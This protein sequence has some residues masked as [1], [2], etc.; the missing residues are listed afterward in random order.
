MYWDRWSTPCPGR[1]TP[2]EDTR[3]PLYRRLGGSI[4][5]RK[6]SSQPRVDRR[7]VH[8]VEIRSFV[9]FVQWLVIFV[10][11]QYVILR[12]VT[13]LAPRIV[14]WLLDFCKICAPPDYGQCHIWY[15]ISKAVFYISTG[16][17]FPTSQRL[18]FTN[19]QDLNQKSILILFCVYPT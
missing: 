1:W 15:L 3:Y 16:I 14:G 6:I 7:N 17:N 4:R 9:R 18:L 2:G 12:H 11:S 13:F 19:T 10:G 8:P 5:V